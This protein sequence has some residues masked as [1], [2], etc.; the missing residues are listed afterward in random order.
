MELREPH[1]ERSTVIS[2]GEEEEGDDDEQ[3]VE[4]FT[5]LAQQISSRVVANARHDLNE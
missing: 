2:P 1:H 4:S 3:S 5:A